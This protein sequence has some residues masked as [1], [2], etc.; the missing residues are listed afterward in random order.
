M[1]RMPV[2]IRVIRAIRGYVRSRIFYDDARTCLLNQ[3]TVR[4]HAIFA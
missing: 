2:V 4:C 1:T 3:S